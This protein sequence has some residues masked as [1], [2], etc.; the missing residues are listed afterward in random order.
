MCGGQKKPAELHEN[1]LKA[2]V[3]FVKQS[4]YFL[5]HQKY[6]NDWEDFMHLH[7]RQIFTEKCFLAIR[8]RIQINISDTTYNS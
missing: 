2:E 4:S 1:P 5:T 7:I 6:L 3:N 8:I